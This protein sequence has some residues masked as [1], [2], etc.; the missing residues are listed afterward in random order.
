M[1]STRTNH[2]FYQQLNSEVLCCGRRKV[3]ELIGEV[4]TCDA[5]RF[6]SDWNPF[7]VSQN[8]VVVAPGIGAFAENGRTYF[9]V[10]CA[11]FIVLLRVLAT[12][13]V[14]FLA[15]CSF[16]PLPDLIPHHIFLTTVGIDEVF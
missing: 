3:P 11:F 9:G 4:T 15:V 6:G 5:N 10:P 14:G 12:G 1:G 16:G 2:G 13:H 8:T 7:Q